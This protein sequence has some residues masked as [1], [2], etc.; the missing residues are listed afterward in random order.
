MKANT[1]A[2]LAAACGLFFIGAPAS[3]GED[4]Q[5][6]YSLA[7]TLGGEIFASP[8]LKGLTG[9]IA[10]TRVD[11]H[12]LTGDDGNKLTQTTPGGTVPLPAPTPSAL[13]PTY[14]ANRVLVHGTGSLVQ[15]NLGLL[16]LTETTYNGGRIAVGLN[17]P[18][19]I[20]KQAFRAEGATP[21]LRWN[22]AVPAP[23]QAAVGARFGAQYQSTLAATADAASGDVSGIGDVE[24]SLGWR[25]ATEQLRVTVGASL[26][27]PTGKY[28][29]EA[30]PD[31]GFGNFYTLRPAAQVVYLPVPEVALAG[32]L[33][34]GFNTTN[35]DNDLRSGNWATLETAAG[36]KSR[37]GVFGVHLLHA[38]QY[39]DDRNSPWGSSRYRSTNGGFFYTA[40][41][42]DRDDGFVIT[43]QRMASLS[44][45]NAKHGSYSQIRVSKS[46]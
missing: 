24:L 16:Y 15:W 21:A 22:P 36:Y 38:Q 1:N 34:L 18:Y 17:L 30:G 37:V 44:S 20:K 8:D 27:L 12:R 28:N 3:A 5:I 23:T 33:T 4:F 13:Y 2:A 10:L 9:G 19:G 26:V 40:R 42:P 41:F 32:R 7:G 43:L 39:Q 25:Q 46:F 6:R 29:D 45:R 11:V 31:I 14:G 35:R